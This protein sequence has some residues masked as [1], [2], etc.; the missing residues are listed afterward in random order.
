ML[1]FTCYR[2]SSEVPGSQGASDPLMVV[3]VCLGNVVDRG[4]V[5]T[6]KPRVEVDC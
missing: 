4:T 3:L 2:G 5:V 1:V 6:I